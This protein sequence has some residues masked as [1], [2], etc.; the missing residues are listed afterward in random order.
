M[1]MNESSL[2]SGETA[3]ISGADEQL[4]V[5]TLTNNSKYEKPHLACSVAQG[6]RTS[7]L[8]ASGVTRRVGE[9]A[10]PLDRNFTFRGLISQ[11]KV[12][13]WL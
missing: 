5:S 9:T 13:E 6:L 3:L 1:R 7:L 10:Q 11:G 8:L 4:I 2:L 12:G